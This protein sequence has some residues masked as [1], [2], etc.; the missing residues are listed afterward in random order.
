MI[1]RLN[2]LSSR[3][4]RGFTLIELLV[5]IAIIAVL[6]SLLLPAVQSARE[7]ARRMQCTNNLKQ[8]ALAAYNY[9]SAN[10]CFPAVG[11][12]YTR[13]VFNRTRVWGWGHSIFTRTLPYFD[14]GPVY[15]GMNFNV[16]ATEPQNITFAGVGMAT[17]WCPSDPMMIQPVNLV[18]NGASGYQIGGGYLYNLPPGATWNQYNSSYSVS[19][20]PFGASNEQTFGMS[21][22]LDYL[23][24]D[25]GSV[26]IANVTD[27]T[28]NTIFYS[29][30]TLS[31]LPAGSQD[32]GIV[33]YPFWNLGDQGAIGFDSQFAP[34]PKRYFSMSSF[35][36][37]SYAPAIASS[38]HPGGVNCAFADGSVKFI[39][40]TINSWP[41][42]VDLSANGSYGAPQS[43]FTVTY[44]PS[45]LVSLTPVAQIGVWQ[46][47]TTKSWGEVISSDQY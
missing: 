14:Q 13:L 15:A 36:L 25:K 5:V 3:G 35:W 1:S 6:I 18:A 29:E 26:K 16:P 23:G 40:D 27:G 28:S 8:L 19:Q 9:E 37:T 2:P 38:N 39:K 32:P 20:G 11:M 42:T 4:R 41:N 45:V 47:L 31:Y 10:G 7:A 43:Y 21:Y 12:D 46:A 22:R 30:H 24:N 17:L 34:N 44:S 33:Q